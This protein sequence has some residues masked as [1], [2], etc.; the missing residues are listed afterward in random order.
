[1]RELDSTSKDDAVVCFFLST[2]Y[3]AADVSLASAYV[4]GKVIRLAHASFR[5][6]PREISVSVE[7]DGPNPSF[8]RLREMLEAGIHYSRVMQALRRENSSKL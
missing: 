1:M 5:D 8:K 4:E 2:K 7:F 3:G 6:G